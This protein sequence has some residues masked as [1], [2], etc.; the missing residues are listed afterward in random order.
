MNVT[1]SLDDSLVARAR[2]LARARG[3]SLNQLIRDQLETLA[4]GTSPSAA[5][6]ELEELWKSESPDREI[7][8]WS[9][10]ELYDRPVLR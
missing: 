2:E 6:S 3:V 10:E 9:R 1:L 5:I 8:C 7:G 4:K